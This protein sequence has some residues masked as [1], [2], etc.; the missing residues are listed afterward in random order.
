MSEQTV[1]LK[2]DV[3]PHY[4]LYHDQFKVSQAQKPLAFKLPGGQEKDDPTFGL[5]RVH[6]GQVTTQIQVKPNQ[7]YQITWQGCA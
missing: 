5:T 2:W 7:Q 1:E 4:D 3:V 6:Y